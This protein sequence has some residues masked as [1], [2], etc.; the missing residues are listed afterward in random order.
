MVLLSP[1]IEDNEGGEGE[2][3]GGGR[4]R[5]SKV[6]SVS[7]NKKHVNLILHRFSLT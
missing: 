7:E 1:N 6:P 3:K 4:T 2:E 5:I